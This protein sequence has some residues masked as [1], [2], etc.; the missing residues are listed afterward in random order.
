LVIIFA[1]L[2]S[3]EDRTPPAEG[4]STVVRE[5]VEHSVILS[6]SADSVDHPQRTREEKGKDKVGDDMPIVPLVER[7][8][9]NLLP[10]LMANR[11]EDETRKIF[12]REETEGEQPELVVV[13]HLVEMP[14]V[15]RAKFLTS[16]FKMK[17]F[18]QKGQPTILPSSDPKLTQKTMRVEEQEN[19]LTTSS[20][21]ISSFHIPADT[22]SLSDSD[23]ETE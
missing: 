11:A 13:G 8:K 12:P 6:S 22:G 18:T 2:I 9:V 1:P 3:L 17:K 7:S 20:P 5:S 21:G 14:E 23:K 19:L 15:L 4:A 10:N 16:M